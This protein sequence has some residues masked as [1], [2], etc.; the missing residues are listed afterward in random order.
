M[1]TSNE[2][3]RSTG[4]TYIDT[5]QRYINP[6]IVC[7][8]NLVGCGSVGVQDVINSVNVNAFPNPA[9]TNVTISSNTSSG[10]IKSVRMFD[11]TGREVLYTSNLNT[12]TYQINRNDLIAGIYLV[13][14]QT[15]KGRSSIKVIFE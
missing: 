4:L 5:I 6:R 13:Q 12:A 1:A 3:G 7:A 2:L 9:N 14:V 15:E 11:V 8:L 10:Q